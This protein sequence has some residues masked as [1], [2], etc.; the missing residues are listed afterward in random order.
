M[1][2]IGH[3]IPGETR[4]QEIPLKRYLQPLPANVVSHYVAACTSPGDFVLDPLAQ[5][6]TLLVEAAAQGRNG[7]ATSFNPVNSLLVHGLLTLPSPQEIDSATTQLGDSL[8]RGVPL[9]EHIQQLYASTCAGC[10]QPT[11]PEYFLWDGEDDRPV[12]KYCHCPHCG[13][14]GRFPVQDADL[15]VLDS[16]E[17]QGVHYWYLLERLAQ[18]HEPE[19]KLAEELLELYTPRNL[20]ALTDLSMKIETL[21][22]DS[23]L[24]AALQLILVH[25]LDTCSKLGASPLPRPTALR[26]HPQSRFVERNVWHAFE[27]AYQQ[28]RRLSPPPEVTVTSDLEHLVS[29]GSG[30]GIVMNEPLR[31]VAAALPPASVSLVIAAPAPYYRPFWTLSYLWSGWLWGREKA[32]LLKPLLRRKT[33]GWSWYR[34]RLC[35]ALK[36]VHR[37]LRRQGRM[38][39]ILEHADLTHIT[40]LILAAV[41]AAFKLDRILYQPEDIHPVKRPMRGAEGAYRL[42]FTR[43]DRAGQQP[44]ELSPDPLAAALQEAALRAARELLTER[45]EALHF[46]WLH[47]VIYQRWSRDELLGQALALEE[48]V[49]VADF[50]EEHLGVGL[51][52]GLM[53][54]V[55][56]LLPEDPDEENGHRL[57]WLKG[58]GYPP[59]P[60][61]DRLEQAVCE[62]LAHGKDLPYGV[63][64]DRIYS[65]FPGIFTPAPGLVEACI[66]SYARDD[67][68]STWHLR[69]ED[70]ATTLARERVEVLSLL[71]EMGHRLGYQVSA[72]AKRVQG[73]LTTAEH[74][75]RTRLP[76]GMDVAWKEEG[77]VC[78]VFAFRQST[79]LGDVLSDARR[80]KSEGRR[81][82][83][84]PDRRLDLLRFRLET[85]LLL[86]RALAEGEWQFIKLSHLTVLTSRKGLDRQDLGQVVGL[87]PLIERPEV[88]L[89]LFPP[90]GF[91]DH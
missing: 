76:K 71:V 25:C 62:A 69:P 64:E 9:R 55:L 45:G 85:E 6:G 53:K 90:S 4:E 15:E 91:D 50:L 39:F 13:A 68:T 72:A 19:R 12:E 81:Y 2:E 33:M 23:P 18:P 8:K 77:T 67:S 73:L 20:S 42:T 58:K 66:H 3:F 35:A 74:T 34:K 51:Q 24:Q 17:R 56:E 52:E 79:V 63:L 82:I 75:S 38:V 40:N 78:H 41:G 10:L 22:A 57:W 86:R 16:I 43:H 65:R 21:F 32:A 1:N 29:E 14:D 46:S 36:T 5:T 28:V 54:G 87:E 11:T 61:G 44:E 7:I 26:L 27:E 30:N 89:S 70:E 88:Q 49:A 83:V 31:Q 59:R 60:L 47:S 48:E 84:V 37:P 80:R